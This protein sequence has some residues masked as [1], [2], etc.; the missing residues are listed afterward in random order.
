VLT[1]WALSY[2]TGVDGELKGE[3]ALGSGAQVYTVDKP[4][5]GSGMLAGSGMRWRLEIVTNDRKL[6]LRAGSE[7][8]MIEWLDAIREA[9]SQAGRFLQTGF[10]YKCGHKRE[11]WKQRWVTVG[12]KGLKY[13]TAPN[14]VL[15]GEVVFLDNDVHVQHTD[16]CTPPSHKFA[17]TVSTKRRAA[18]ARGAAWGGGGTNRGHSF[19]LL[20]APTVELRDQWLAA[21]QHAASVERT[22]RA[23]EGS[24]QPRLQLGKRGEGLQLASASARK[25]ASDVEAAGEQFHGVDRSRGMRMPQAY[26]TLTDS[27]WNKLSQMTFRYGGGTELGATF[28]LGRGSLEMACRLRA[29]EGVAA[30]GRRL[31]HV[32]AHKGS[33]E[34]LAV[35]ANSSSDLS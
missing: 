8:V 16:V 24:A 3:L 9:V 23:Q 15:K 25:L 28:P 2:Y 6:Q 5:S 17:F 10:L 18:A 1:P 34:V 33:G 22:I 14:G 20:A 31:P 29:D 7:S 19:L 12:H 30:P 21:L 32:E 4:G 11:T 35:L 13:F 26:N 27:A